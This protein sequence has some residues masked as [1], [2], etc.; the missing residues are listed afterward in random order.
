M[1]NRERALYERMILLYEERI[2][3]LETY[4]GI[5]P[6]ST[7]PVTVLKAPHEL[8]TPMRAY[9]VDEDLED[10]DYAV[11]SNQVGADDAARI[12][13]D[14]DFRNTTVEDYTFRN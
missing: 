8:R 6:V 14:F 1:R 9:D 11:R 4:L 5:R 7:P 10:L 12:L 13:E 2:D 3:R